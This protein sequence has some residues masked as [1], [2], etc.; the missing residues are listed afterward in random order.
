MLGRV[1][2]RKV[3]RFCLGTEYSVEA[4]D[5]LPYEVSCF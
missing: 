1:E 5:L 4:Y 2:Q 3:P